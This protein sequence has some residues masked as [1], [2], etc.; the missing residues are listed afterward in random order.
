MLLR[1]RHFEMH[2]FTLSSICDTLDKIECVTNRW[3]AQEE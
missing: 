3:S 2:P 1:M